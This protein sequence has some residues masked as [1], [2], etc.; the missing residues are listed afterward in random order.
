MN[1]KLGFFAAVMVCG[2]GLA[3]PAQ[4]Q[5][6]S[7]AYAQAGALL[8]Y[9]EAELRVLYAGVT[10]REYDPKII[11]DTIAELKRA[12]GDA[13]R[14]VGRVGTLL[15]DDLSKHQPEVEKL[16]LSISKAEDQLTKLTNDIDEQTKAL[17]GDDAEPELG[18][19]AEADEGDEAPKVDW[20]LLKAGI[21]WLNVD[22][23]EAKKLYA[24][25]AKKL[26]M[27][28]LKVPP[29]PRGKRPE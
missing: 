10:A 18:E 29:K 15:P 6:Y 5:D 23:G 7:L 19:R 20:E 27:A 13:K 16:R 26:K 1:C 11:K 12:I 4:A 3:R 21:G 22:V 8:T 17:A 25:V 24:G 28:G 2:V 14:Q 9:S